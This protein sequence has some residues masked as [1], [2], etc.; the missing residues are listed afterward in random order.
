MAA[1]GYIVFHAEQSIAD[2]HALLRSLDSSARSAQSALADLRAAEQAYVASGQGAAFW[3]PKVTSLVETAEEHVD[4]L[5]STAQSGEARAR[6]MEASASLAEFKNV[7]QRAR[8]YL[9][10]NQLLMAADV[11]FTEGGETVVAAGRQ[12]D[13]AVVVEQ[14]AFD[15][16]EAAQRKTQLYALF[17][18]GG[19]SVLVLLLLLPRGR[20]EADAADVAAEAEEAETREEAARPGTPPA[21]SP[22]EEL[23]RASAPV[24][25]TAAALCTDFGR[26]RDLEDL[27]HLLGRAADALDA[28]GLVV[29][30]GTAAGGNLRPVVAHGYAQQLLDRMPPI[31][32]SADNAAAAAYR[33]GALQIV[34]ARP[35]VSSGALVAPLVA[36]EGCIGSLTAEIRG[37]AE[38]SDAVQSLAII[39]AA[40]LAGVLAGSAQADAAQAPPRAANL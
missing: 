16:F 24:L 38:S 7:D 34:L 25:K 21:P 3:M 35:G 19:I 36:P 39:F 20:A 37:G 8:D 14:Q 11:V 27:Q 9:K 18:A 6:L 23:P 29:W 26:V 40:Q 12:V 17:T 31:P 10:S 15:A 28:T 30:L 22:A 1:S 5:R 13:A 2:R 32:R 33:T 4:A